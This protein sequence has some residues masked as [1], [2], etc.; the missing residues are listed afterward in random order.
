MKFV[1]GFLHSGGTGRWRG[2]GTGHGTFRKQSGRE[3]EHERFLK[4][5]KA[6][7]RGLFQNL[8]QENSFSFILSAR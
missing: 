8:K 4:Q 2:G 5:N 1:S 7:Q 6:K 3:W